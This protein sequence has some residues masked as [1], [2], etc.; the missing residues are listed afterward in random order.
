MKKNYITPVIAD[1]NID[2]SII[3]M[4]ESDHPPIHEEGEDDY[5]EGSPAR[6]ILQQQDSPFGNRTIV[7]NETFAPSSPF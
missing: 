6:R 3:L 5:G 2:S 4:M 7:E 1:Y